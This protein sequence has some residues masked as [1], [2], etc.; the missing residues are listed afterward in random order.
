MR[1]F[2]I[3]TIFSLLTSCTFYQ[4]RGYSFSHEDYDF[5]KVGISTKHYI[6]QKMGE[7]SLYDN[8][9]WTYIGQKEK[10]YLFFRPKAFERKIIFIE[11]DHNNIVSYFKQYDIYSQKEINF[12][13]D[14]TIT[15]IENNNSF[16]EVL[17][18]TFNN[19][20]QISPN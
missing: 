18:N 8:N 4:N 17:K 10:K 13:Q 15:D 1:L 7:P 5:I 11:F 16:I 2:L 9:S 20:G 19:I 3:L 12:N 6:S 14:D